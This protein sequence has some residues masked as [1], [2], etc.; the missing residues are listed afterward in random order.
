MLRRRGIDA[1]FHVGAKR[2]QPGE[3]LEAHAWVELDGHTIVGY[4]PN[5][6]EYFALSL[7]E[8]GGCA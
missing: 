8:R 4:L 2:P 6:S 1:R 3:P 5:L 7:Q